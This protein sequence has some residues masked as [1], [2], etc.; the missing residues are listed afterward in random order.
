MKTAYRWAIFAASTL[1]IAGIATAIIHGR[2]E[3]TAVEGIKYGILQE[4]MPQI[5]SKAEITSDDS[6]LTVKYS[7][8]E[9]EFGKYTYVWQQFDDNKACFMRYVEFN[10]CPNA[11]R[12]DNVRYACASTAM[13]DYGC[14]GIVD[15]ISS[16][17][18]GGSVNT[19]TREEREYLFEKSDVNSIFHIM[20]SVLEAEAGIS[21]EEE[22]NRWHSIQ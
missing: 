15:E 8:N 16:A 18:I 4:Q 6:T 14:D 19:A 9:G 11:R 17:K 10:E 12:N 7:E 3:I 21:L 1:G 20:E 22:V 2:H 13:R 5:Q